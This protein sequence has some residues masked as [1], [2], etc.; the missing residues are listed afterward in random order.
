MPVVNITEAANLVGVAR[1]TLYRKKEQGVLSFTELPDGSPG[2][3][4]GELYRVY[5]QQS[6]D[7]TRNATLATDAAPE[8]SRKIAE[9][10][11]E[12][13]LMREQLA[14]SQEREK[15]AQERERAAQAAAQE[16]EQWLQSQVEKLTDTIKQIEHRAAPEQTLEPARRSWLSRIFGRA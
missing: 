6:R 13:R 16:R 14:V 9:L 3:D 2:I 1:S 11:L 8:N 4:T 15:T 10:Q 7:N 5:P 12:L